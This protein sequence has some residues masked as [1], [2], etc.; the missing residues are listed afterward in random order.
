M[1]VV[2]MQRRIR[3][4]VRGPQDDA[5]AFYLDDIRICFFSEEV[6]RT[7]GSFSVQFCFVYDDAQQGLRFE[8]S[9][10]LDLQKN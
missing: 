8:S 10:H 5:S 6:E 7:H 1:F 2:E 9:L 3:H 4:G